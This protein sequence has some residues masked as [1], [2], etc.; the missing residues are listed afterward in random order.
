MKPP[1]PE[2]RPKSVAGLTSRP[3]GLESDPVNTYLCFILFLLVAELLLNTGVD[4]ANL[5]HLR[6]TIPSE[7]EG[8][9]DQEKY[10]RSQAY[11][12]D[13][14][15][16]EM[17]SS[18][19]K[20]PIL[21]GFI[22]GGGFAWADTLARGGGSGVVAVGLIFA[23]ILLLLS[24]L[25][26]LPFSLY[27]TFVLEERYGFNKTRPGTFVADL[28]KEWVLLALVGGA[29]F[30]VI[31]WFFSRFAWAWLYSWIALTLIQILLM[32]VAPVFIMPLFNRFTP[33]EEGELNDAV[34]DYA[35][36]QGFQLKGIFTMDGSRRST[37]SNAYFTGFGR[38]RR[39]VLFDTLVVN[40]TVA[41]LVSI[42]AHEVGHY[43]LRHIHRMMLVS[44]VSTGVMF[45]LLSLFISRPGLYGAFGVP[46]EPVGDAMPVY[47]GLVFFGFLYTPISRLLGI[48]Q[49]RLSRRHEFEADAFAARTAGAP[50]AM[51]EAL[52]KLSVDNL[53]NLTPHAWKVWLEYSHPPVLQRIAA[54]RALD[55]KEATAAVSAQ[56]A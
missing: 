35:K 54:L 16:F 10:A 23:G 48:V 29:V 2:A 32:Y 3:Q 17:V 5:R 19:L 1:A 49:N 8:W 34:S 6:M 33:L 52:K 44:V 18:L 43:K 24:Q 14:T 42:F 45:Y 38:W 31:I 20:T 56:G 53:S 21:V 15:R 27:S 26:E 30:S 51:I 28:I 47:A 13:T 7:F 11:L 50:E 39:I 37:K 41:E 40:H 4:L 55:A 12:K 25:L 36:H 9:Y 22:L 46:M